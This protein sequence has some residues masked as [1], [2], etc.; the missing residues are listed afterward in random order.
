MQIPEVLSWTVAQDAVVLYI[1]S[2]YLEP[3]TELAWAYRLH[4]YI[5]FRT[6]W[7]RS[8]FESGDRTASLERHLAAVCENHS[9]HLLKHKTYPDHIRCLIS[10]RPDHSISKVVNT[11]KSN[12]S[13]QFS[14]DFGLTPPL[15]ATGHLARSIGRVNIQVVKQY[16]LDQAEHH[17][18]ASR[19][20][21]PVF[22]YRAS[23]P[24]PLTAKHAVF[25]LTHHL[26]LATRYRRGVFSRTLGG[27]LIEYWL[28]VAST[29]GFAIDQATVLPDHVH[30][31]LRLT[32]K[33]SI[34]QCTLCLMNNS[35]HWMGTRHGRALVLAGIDQLWQPSAYAG[36]C[37]KVTTAQVKAFL[38][39]NAG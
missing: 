11:L 13:R 37:G 34:E 12:V 21:P 31:L 16:L 33:M 9:Y 10:L 7:R 3:L 26:V 6:R 29:R 28:R 24:L 22:K 39:L 38:S 27:D 25:D 8:Q 17:G 32:S 20:N 5:C 36:T 14:A 30:L 19:V 35:Q 2:V 4:Y 1:S 23:N 18:Y 15:W